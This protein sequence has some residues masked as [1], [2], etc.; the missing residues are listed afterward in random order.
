MP[1]N[2]DTLKDF[3]HLLPDIGAVFR[4]VFESC[5]ALPLGLPSEADFKFELIGS[6]GA[7]YIDAT[8]HRCIE[9]YTGGR[10][11]YPNV[12]IF[13]TSHGKGG[14]FAIESIKH[15]VDC[16]TQ[17]FEPIVSGEDGLAVTRI[18]EGITRSADSGKPVMIS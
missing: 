14:G 17:D 9:K 15:F 13:P 6:E 3:V 11:S 2:A 16:V 8:H 12:L 10:A 4:S 18:I 1:T 5:W 7:I